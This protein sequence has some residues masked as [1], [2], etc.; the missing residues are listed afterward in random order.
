PQSD[1]HLV[2]GGA[3]M[4]NLRGK[5]NVLFKVNESGTEDLLRHG[6]IGLL[7]GMNLH[8]SNAVQA[9]TKGTGASYT[10]STAGF[11]AGTTNIPLITGTGTVL[12][13]DIVTFAGDP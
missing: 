7:E 12:A 10:S 1:L 11:A 13:G 9:Q 6:V 2:M 5:Q 3:A 8:N 4:A